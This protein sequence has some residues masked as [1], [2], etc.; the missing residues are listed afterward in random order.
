MISGVFAINSMVRQM[1][2]PLN[3]PFILRLTVP[4]VSVPSQTDNRVRASRSVTGR[5]PIRSQSW[6]LSMLACGR[7]EEMEDD[8][9]GSQSCSNRPHNHISLSLYIYP[10]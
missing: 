1:S 5:Y 7:P 9:N 2:L 3:L 6:P 4:P 10:S 8:Q